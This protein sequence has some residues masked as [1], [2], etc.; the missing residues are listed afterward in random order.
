MSEDQDHTEKDEKL[1]A[2]EKLLDDIEKEIEERWIKTLKLEKERH[3]ELLKDL[4]HK[5]D[6]KLQQADEQIIKLQETISE[7]D[8]QIARY[9]QI[10]TILRQ[11]ILD[12]AASPHYY[13]VVVKVHEKIKMATVVNSNGQPMRV[14]IVND[15]I[16]ENLDMLKPGQEVLLNQNFHILEISNNNIL[17]RGVIVKIEQILEDGTRAIL[18]GRMDEKLVVNIDSKL[19]GNLKPGDSALLDPAT[20]FIF[21]KVEVEKEAQELLLAEI[22]DTNWKDIG[23]LD[24]QIE[25]IQ[26]ELIWPITYK[27]EFDIHK[28]P[29]EKGILLKGPPGCGKTLF[30]KAIA[31]YYQGHFV[32]IGGPRLESKW[33]GE[34]ARMQ[35]EIFGLADKYKPLVIF[36]D[37]AESFLATRGESPGQSHKKDNVTQFLVL[38]DG[39]NKLDSVI[40]L[41][42]TNRPDL[43]DPAVLREGRLGLDIFINRP[44][45]PQKARDIFRIYLTPNLPFHP[46]TLNGKDP[47]EVVEKM[48]NK[49]TDFIFTKNE[50]TELIEVTDKDGTQETFY[51]SDFISGARIETI[52]RR[53]KMKSIINKIEGGQRGITTKGVMQSIKEIYYEKQGSITISALYQEFILRPGQI[54]VIIKPL[55]IEKKIEKERGEIKKEPDPTV[56]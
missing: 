43:I 9:K 23:G 20:G 12:L 22:P 6:Q 5:M 14:N 44:N 26:Q 15:E 35:R 46:N 13:G 19:H 47:E 29:A 3:T 49:A 25:T 56:I 7:K 21:E 34:T 31:N 42:A 36:F 53:A 8:D 52:V 16:L 4:Q 30:G 41:A 38:M 54:P 27:Q 39:I 11:K 18:Q 55:I 48:I 50:A 17:A 28:Q 10:V 1:A 2:L 32:Y 40:V 37:D 51:F 45:T 24:E 33:V